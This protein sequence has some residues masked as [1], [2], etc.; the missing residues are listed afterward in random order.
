MSPIWYRLRDRIVR[1][2]I[3]LLSHSD[4]LATNRLHAMPLGLLLGI[5][6]TAFDNFYGKLSSYASTWLKDVDNLQFITE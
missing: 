2:G 5:E 6:V 4:A 1:C 3:A